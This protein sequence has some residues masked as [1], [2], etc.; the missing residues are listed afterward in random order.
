MEKTHDYQIISDTAPAIERALAAQ[1]AE[2]WRPILM[3]TATINTEQVQV[4]I[5]LELLEVLAIQRGREPEHRAG[6]ELP[7]HFEGDV[8]VVVAQE[9]GPEAHHE[10]QDL[11]PVHVVDVPA[12]PV[13]H[14]DGVGLEPPDVRLN[15][16]RGTPAGPLVELLA[17][18]VLREI[19]PAESLGWH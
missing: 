10:V 14:D 8:P 18:L 13:V 17:P 11:V 1:S 15:A 19:P 2:G 3:S 6:F 7:D 5:G 12:I 4:F 16:A 9:E